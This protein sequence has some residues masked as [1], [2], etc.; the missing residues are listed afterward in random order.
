VFHGWWHYQHEI[1]GYDKDLTRIAENGHGGNPH[2][3]LSRPWGWLFL[4]RP[5]AYY[6]T[7]PHNAC[8]M[9]GTSYNQCSSEILGIGNPAIWWMS[10]PAFIG[11]AWAWIARRDW[12]ASSILVMF[13]VGFVPWCISDFKQRVM[14]L[15]YMLPNVPFMV[16][17]LTL[18]IGMAIGSKR[19]ATL[20]RA[21]GLAG[22][23]IYLG[24]V[25]VLFGFFYPVLSAQT[26]TYAH[27]HERIWFHHCQSNQNQHEE[28][29][30]CWI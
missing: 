24:T 4:A 22:V 26:M 28:D 15:F 12:R 3:Y 5:V 19:A 27:W 30:P 10:I 16:F 14:F 29:A 23:S 21:V 7:S 13:L 25:V 18:L 17:A 9:T 20:R 11:T 6:Y 2:P 1:W 8:G